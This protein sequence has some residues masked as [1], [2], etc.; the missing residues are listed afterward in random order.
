MDIC[1]LCTVLSH[2][3]SSS[4]D[5][6]VT[7]PTP[8]SICG[9]DQRQLAGGVGNTRQV[10]KQA[11]FSPHRRLPTQSWETGKPSTAQE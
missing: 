4:E 9:D 5:I 7:D 3:S 1:H 8:S 10:K 2:S 6:G 11:L